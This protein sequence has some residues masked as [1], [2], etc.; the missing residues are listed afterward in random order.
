MEFVRADGLCGCSRRLSA[1]AL[2]NGKP[3]LL[4][5]LCMVFV[6]SWYGLGMVLAQL[7]FRIRLGD[8]SEDMNLDSE[9]KL[10]NLVKALPGKVSLAERETDQDG[11]DTDRVGGCM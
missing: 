1:D 7:C 2:A 3:H 4:R 9:Y 6:W 8:W 11:A 10:L 5:G